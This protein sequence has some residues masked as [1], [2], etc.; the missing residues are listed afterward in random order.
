MPI[1][2]HS[3][4]WEWVCQYCEVIQQIPR[5]LLSALNFLAARLPCWGAT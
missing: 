5:L 1:V 4:L 2:Q 3:R